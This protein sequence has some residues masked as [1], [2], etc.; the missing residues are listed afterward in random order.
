MPNEA[1][2]T[3]SSGITVLTT[4]AVVTALYFGREFL[5][6]IALSV[7]FAALLRPVVR[8]MEH[9]RIPAPAGAT[10]ILVAITGAATVAGLAAAGPIREWVA[11]APRTLG[12]ARHRL[13]ELRRP[14][15][16]LSA[17]AQ[18]AAGTEGPGAAGGRDRGASPPGGSVE[19]PSAPGL[20]VR[21]FGTTTSLV[22]EAVEVLLLTFLLLASGDTFLTKL[23]NV[24]H[25]RREK[26]EAVRVVREA[27]GAV[28]HYM[29]AT[30][31]IN[32]GQGL[33]VGLA[34]W[35]LHLPNP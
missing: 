29:V 20:A 23:V 15:D 5:V 6:P 12:A 13:Q 4:L 11:E 32:V 25:V 3:R 21:I 10:I 35:L 31:L 34:M 22:G 8:W 18:R 17:A 26:V 16:R 27:E 14:F 30:A 7:L 28:S 19:G 33:I 9:A 2:P 1:T 24:L